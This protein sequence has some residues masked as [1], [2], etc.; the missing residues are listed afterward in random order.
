VEHDDLADAG[1]E[2]LVMPSSDGPQVDVADGTTRVPAKLKVHQRFPVGYVHGFPVDVHQQPRLDNVSGVDLATRVG[3]RGGANFCQR[4]MFLH[5]LTT[6]D[7]G[8]L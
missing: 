1:L 2:N 5:A 7:G 4:L 6:T 3:D 8:K